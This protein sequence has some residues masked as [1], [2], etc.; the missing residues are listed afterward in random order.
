HEG[1]ERSVSIEVAP[2]NPTAPKKNRHYLVLFEEKKHERKELKN[3]A[4][5]KQTIQQTGTTVKA[6]DQQIKQLQQELVSQH[7]YQQSLIEQFDSTQEEL[8]AANE[9]LQAMNEE[10]QSTNEELETAKEELQAANEEL[11]TMNDELQ[12]R[13]AELSFL[14]EELARAQDR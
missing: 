11:T 2:I 9:E 5:K 3:E 13:N 8:T 7:D 12:N 1:L 6:K 14:N 10:L 4:P